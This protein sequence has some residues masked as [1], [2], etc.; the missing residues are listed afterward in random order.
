VLQI[1]QSSADASLATIGAVDDI[2][3][4][5]LNSGVML[6]TEKSMS[7][8]VRSYIKSS[9]I[10]HQIYPHEQNS[11]PVLPVN[12]SLALAASHSFALEIT[13]SRSLL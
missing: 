10:L 5:M 11:T 4:D 7:G 13:I 12:A 3:P 1:K 9:L 8:M 6:S 2:R